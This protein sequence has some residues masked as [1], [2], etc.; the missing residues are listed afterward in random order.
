MR[1]LP[2]A[3]RPTS[4]ARWGDGPAGLMVAVAFILVLHRRRRRQLAAVWTSF[5]HEILPCHKRATD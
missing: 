5:Q 3:L 1:R 4:Y 2:R